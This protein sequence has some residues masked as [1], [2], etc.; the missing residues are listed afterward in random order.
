MFSAVPNPTG[1]PAGAPAAPVW[2]PKGIWGTVAFG[3][4][5]ELDPEVVSP[6]TGSS[7][8]WVSSNTTGEDPFPGMHGAHCSGSLTPTPRRRAGRALAKRLAL[9]RGGAAGDSGL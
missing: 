1:K 5:V 6:R 4:S 7:S 8:P 9:Q 3:S 2:V